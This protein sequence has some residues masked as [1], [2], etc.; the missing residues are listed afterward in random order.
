MTENTT[1][2][3]R[4]VYALTETVDPAL[5]TGEEARAVETLMKMVW[6]LERAEREVP[7]E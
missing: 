2:L 4:I 6:R 7:H 1:N 5:L 3:K